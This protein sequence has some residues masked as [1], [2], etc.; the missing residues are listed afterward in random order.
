MSWP[1][2]APCWHFLKVTVVNPSF[3]A[4]TVEALIGYAKASPGKIDM[5]SSGIGS[6]PHV[7]GE[8]VKMM[9]GVKMMHVPYRG[10]LPAITDLLAGQ[11]H[12]YFGTLPASIEYVKSG[13]LR[14][15]AVTGATRSSA[16]PD[17]PTLGE[18]LRGYEATIWNGLNA[19]R[20]TPPGAQPGDQRGARRCQV[21]ASLNWAQ[22]LSPARLPALPN[23]SLRTPRSE[24]RS[25]GPPK[26]GWNNVIFH[27]LCSANLSGRG[28]LL[29]IRSP[30]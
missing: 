23:S 4:G 2:A 30:G 18:F 22:P 7:A 13:N 1:I 29:Q 14:A 10:D 12:V 3:P 28:C 21:Q 19:P 9:A 5:A 6:P 15:L 26:S 27:I 24:P 8:L 16:L 11:V 20:N 25:C 17:V